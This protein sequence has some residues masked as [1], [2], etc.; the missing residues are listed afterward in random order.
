MRLS[1]V[2]KK[3]IV[4]L[5]P[6]LF[7]S[8]EKLDDIR[9][10]RIG[11]IPVSDAAYIFK[12]TENTKGS[13]NKESEGIWKITQDGEEVKLTI[14]NNKGDET[15]IEINSVVNITE[16]YL[17]VTTEVGRVLV[18][19]KTNKVYECPDNLHADERVEEY[20]QGTIYYS[21]NWGI[22]KSQISASTIK[23]E[24][25]LP[26]GQYGSDFFIGKNETIY[27]NHGLCYDGGG[28]IMTKNKRLYPT[29]NLDLVFGSADHN[30]YSINQHIDIDSEGYEIYKWENLSENEIDKKLICTIPASM[31]PYHYRS[32]NFAPINTVNGNVILF[33]SNKV[34]E[35]DGKSCK[36]KREYSPKEIEILEKLFDNISYLNGY[37]N[38]YKTVG[39][40]N[41]F[42]DHNPGSGGNKDIAVSI[43]PTTYELKSIPYIIPENEYE[44]YSKQTDALC[45]KLLFTALR[46]RDSSIVLGEVDSNGNV[47][48]IS[49]RK[50]TYNITEYFALN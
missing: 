34:Y 41:V 42:F 21:W 14:L 2:I 6:F 3:A 16:K 39:N 26:E 43:D 8:C 38:Q 17:L 27:Y 12:R 46:Y 30:I 35:F 1:I 40:N 9:L 5:L 19:K 33:I 25:M 49:E 32:T 36:L 11:S 13:A 15:S 47:K 48:I 44:V 28:K 18:D 22:Y 4:I 45:G 50:S 24:F 10:Q 29:D 20:P 23:E 7:L 37:G 31:E